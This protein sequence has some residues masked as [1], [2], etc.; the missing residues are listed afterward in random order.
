MLTHQL[1]SNFFQDKHKA[2]SQQ[3]F[4][5]R[6]YCSDEEVHILYVSGLAPKPQ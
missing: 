5:I 1:L 6:K 3:P 4:K 2:K